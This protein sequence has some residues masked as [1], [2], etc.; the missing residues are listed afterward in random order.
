MQIQ[1]V[2]VIVPLALNTAF[3][4]KVK[5]ED[6]SCISIGSRVVVPF[7]GRKFYTAIVT[8]I[9]PVPP[10]DIDIKYI[11]QVLDS[12][13]IISK[14][15]LELWNWVSDYYLCTIGEVYRAA[16]PAGLKLESE[17]YVDLSPEFTPE[18]LNNVSPNGREVIFHLEHASKKLSVGQLSK[19]TGI[20]YVSGIITNLLSSGAIIISEKLVE[21]YRTVKQSFVVLQAKKNVAGETTRL[22]ALVKGAR[23][24]EIALM[25]LI[26]LSG[27][28]R[29]DESK[30]TEVP[31]KLLEERAEV[32]PAVINS[33]RQKGIVRIIQ[34][35][36]SRFT[37]NGPSIGTLPHLSEAQNKALNEIHQSWV[38]HN[39][40]LLHGVTSSGKTEIFMHLIDF[41]INQGKNVLFLVPEIALTTQLTTRLQQVFGDKVI[42]YHSKF[43][44]NERVEIWRKILNSNEHHVIIGARSAVFL[45]F[46]SL[47]LVIV[48]EEH[49][50]SYKQQDPAPRYNARD[51]ATILA[52]LYGAK[53]LLASATPSIDTYYKARSGRFGLVT[54]SERYGNIELPVVE[55][56][57]MKTERKS[58]ALSG[59]FSRH[60]RNSVTETIS[61][62]KQAILF[63]NRRGYSPI[64]ECPHCAYVPKC[65]DCDVS[66]TYH[67]RIG[68][69]VCHYCGTEYPMPVVCP[70]CH[71]PGIKPLGYGTERIEEDIEHA[72]PDVP[73][74]RMDLDTTRAKDGYDKI[75][76]EFSKGSSKIL[77]GTQM[78]TKGLDFNN[79]QTVGVIN[80][81][82]MI[83]MPDFRA[84]ERAFNMLEQVAGRAGRRNIQGKVI[85]QTSE[86]T[87]PLLQSIISH[88]YASH[89]AQEI[90]ERH[91]YNFPPFTRLINVFIKHRDP[92]AVVNISRIYADQL[93]KL[94]GNR[95]S[96][97]EEPEISRIQTYYIR[98]IMLKFE[99]EVSM[100][101]VRQILRDTLV[102]MYE[103]GIDSIRQTIF[104]F[105]VD[106]C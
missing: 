66:L 65:K 28:N 13:P 45:P 38:D 106:P 51:T 70:V 16:V 60:L 56:V 11:D 82:A 97:P 62:G 34:R 27:F 76:D 37:Y 93:R 10:K 55:L 52:R 63:L 89:Y 79:V 71:E 31:R 69:L 47:G 99:L 85:I 48:D 40:T 101:K 42:I 35:E 75:I 80:A 17:T 68:K 73:V 44:D 46:R 67:R 33:L 96:G 105:D 102:Y 20:S 49:E 32:A 87:H 91:R 72:F 77:V 15:Q 78:V 29:A 58:G 19:L 8:S 50:S 86:P 5:P 61:S 53:T 81:D 6:A 41:V 21:R 3:T 12:N 18:M 104:A 74:L 88:D 39:V 1:F 54:L 4:Y 25:A 43:S 98:K 23:K 95:V 94:F 22:F 30:C 64:A 26:E 83:H 90:D 100:P 103:T 36:I 2:Q 84:G 57:D 7:G 59:M 14:A 92:E 9:N 24:Q